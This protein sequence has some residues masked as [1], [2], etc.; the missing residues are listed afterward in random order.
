MKI[1]RI[2]MYEG[3]SRNAHFHDAYEL[4]YIVSG[5]CSVSMRG[6]VRSLTPGSSFFTAPYESH[7]VIYDERRTL[8][9][10]LILFSLD[11][12]E[13]EL[14]GHIDTLLAKRSFDLGEGKRFFFETVRM[15][16]SSSTR[17]TALSGIHLFISFLY[18][19]GDDASR[20]FAAE[21]RIEEAL[22]VLHRSLTQR[23]SLAALARRAGLDS[24]YFIRVF[25]KTTGLSPMKYFTRLKVEAACGLL[26]RTDMPIADI[27]ERFCFADQYHFSRT[28][29][30]M[31]GVSPLHYR[32]RGGDM[33]V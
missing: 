10:Y 4:R 8:V 14:K 25:R 2:V 7:T 18:S 6:T 22:A 12:E 16:A 30:Q 27:A 11:A 13:R 19:L 3:A 33:G 17:M 21:P 20:M 24:S 26:S 28:F 1:Q 9:Q 32:R 23:T 31:I 29:K 5:D 15:K